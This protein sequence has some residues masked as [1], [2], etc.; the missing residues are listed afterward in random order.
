MIRRIRLAILR[1]KRSLLVAEINDTFKDMMRFHDAGDDLTAYHF[2]LEL[3]ALYRDLGRLDWR[4]M[5]LKGWRFVPNKER[6]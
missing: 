3:D 2:E 4:L 1:W 5:Q 6:T